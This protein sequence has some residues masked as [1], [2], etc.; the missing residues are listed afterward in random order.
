M[1]IYFPM[2][3][4]C[5]E[6]R[7]LEIKSFLDRKFVFSIFVCFQKLVSFDKSIKRENHNLK[8]HSMFNH[9]CFKCLKYSFR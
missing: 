3:M 1:T 2:E 5:Q 9:E 6:K 7:I 4:N 8:N